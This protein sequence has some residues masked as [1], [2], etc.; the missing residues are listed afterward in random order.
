[1]IIKQRNHPQPGVSDAGS[2]VEP[3]GGDVNAQPGWGVAYSGI[4]R[5]KNLSWCK[6]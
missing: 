4:G 3:V 2:D 6:L 1:M 5:V